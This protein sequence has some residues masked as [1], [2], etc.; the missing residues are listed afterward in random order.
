MID[1][2]PFV[3]Y[4]FV[5]SITPGPNNLMLTAGG[6]NFGFRRTLPHIAGIC[7]G[8]AIQAFAMCAGLGALFDRWPGLQRTLG[9]VG[10][11]YLLFLGW[12][13]LRSTPVQVREG[14]RHVSLLEGLV[15]QFLNPKAWVMSIT[16]AAVFLPREFSFLAR[17]AYMIGIIEALGIPC[18]AIW[19][20]FGSSLKAL[21][22]TPRNRRIF[23][24]SMAVALGA[25]AVAMVAK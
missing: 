10:A 22:A 19:A 16:A 12:Q 23:N 4:T 15:F 6:A 24:I 3:T 5:M 17:N 21:L 8:A 25:T 1:P 2:L 13:M 11:A 18:L 20:L 14:A 7:I 9:W